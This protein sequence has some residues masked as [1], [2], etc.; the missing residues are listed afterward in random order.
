MVIDGDIARGI[1][2]TESRVCG[3]IRP[4]GGPVAQSIDH[5]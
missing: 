4:V 3:L 5:G 1:S 2:G